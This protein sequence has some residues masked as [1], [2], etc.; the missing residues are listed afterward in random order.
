[1]DALLAALTHDAAVRR[2]QWVVAGATCLAVVGAVGASQRLSPSRPAMC[3]GGPERAAAVWGPDRR[4]AIRRAF[5]ASG[6]P[7]APTAFARMSEIFDGYLR[8]WTEMY[9]E[10]C[11][12]THVRGEQSNEVLDLRTECLGE[13][14]S[15]AR[16]LSDVFASANASTVDNAVTA[17]SALPALDRC[18][19]VAM[20]RAVIKPPSDPA[21]RARVAE[22]REQASRVRA[23][24]SAGRCDE[25]ETAANPARDAARAIGYRP[26]EAEVLIAMA[27]LGDE[28]LEPRIAATRFEEAAYAAEASHH[29]EIAIDAASD[30]AGIYADR[31]HDSTLA[32]HWL[33]HA[34][35]TLERLPNH[36][37]QEAWVAVARGLVLMREA[38]F[39]ES[40]AA[41]RQALALK[42]TYLGSEHV[43]SAISM[44]N[45]GEALHELG[46]DDEAEPVLARARDVFARLMGGDSSLVAV[47]LLNHAEVL[48]AVGKFAAARADL[49]RAVE[50]WTADKA[51]PFYMGCALLDRGLLALAERGA[52]AA[53]PLLQEAV[54]VLE[55]YDAGKTAEAEFALA[56]AEPPSARAHAIE[57]ARKARAAMS[58]DPARARRVAEIDRWLGDQP[59]SARR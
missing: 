49:E 9:E 56:R 16:A 43:D 47:V 8:R 58:D 31:L 27:R 18:A 1:M 36:P 55:K 5:M 46:R 12:A 37:V 59:A 11:K 41:Q 29:D 54:T 51:S 35:A 24:A 2:R 30:A 4:D 57:L 25:A 52:A 22:V 6:S 42:E 32:R 23:L 21:V 38:R 40:L 28:C 17:A 50:I 48:T 44:V 20:L 10:S 7:S 33:R 15:A 39:E 26:L 19:D 45:V 3:T 13:R 14:L 34:E 53:R